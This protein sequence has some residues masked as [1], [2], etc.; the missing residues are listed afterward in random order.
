MDTTVIVLGASGFG[1]HHLVNI[2]KLSKTH[3]RLAPDHI[4]FTTTSPESY[5][6]TMD[7]FGK[8]VSTF[9]FEYPSISG[10]TVKK[11]NDLEHLFQ[12]LRHDDIKLITSAVPYA[13]QCEYLKDCALRAPTI[14][15]KPSGSP[16]GGLVV[17]DFL[18]EIQAGTQYHDI[19]LELPVAL[20]REQMPGTEVLETYRNSHRV[21]A[22]W[23]S[24]G[25]LE[26][27]YEIVKAD[28]GP[29]ALSWLPIGSKIVKGKR[30][31]NFGIEFEDTYK[32]FEVYFERVKE[33]EDV[34]KGV[35]LHIG[36]KVVNY[37]IVDG[38]D[39]INELRVL[40][41]GYKMESVKNNPGDLAAKSD[42]TGIEVKNPLGENLIKAM[43]GD[44]VTDLGQMIVEQDNLEKLFK[45]GANRKYK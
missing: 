41:D 42:P 15:E 3:P 7:R 10:H 25:K 23:S 8:T 26:D 21:K 37:V 44:M 38:P 45:Y 35:Q 29:H 13:V 17:S 1:Y 32:D 9:D 36:H 11:P 18:K 33:G 2:A 31:S 19:G 34:F 43:G 24:V 14:L 40:H 16:T 12:E 30:E 20:I 4:A 27:I 6:S 22:W 5:Q 39:Y 28:L